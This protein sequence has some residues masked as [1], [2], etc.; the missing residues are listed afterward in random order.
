MHP[1]LGEIAVARTPRARRITVSVRPPGKV[2]LTMPASIPVAEGM[3]FLESK[4]EWVEAVRER[5]RR[6]SAASGPILPPYSTRAH[7]LE[8]IGRAHV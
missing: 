1:A 8:Q 2:R 4:T 7:T 6:K 5:M 3:R